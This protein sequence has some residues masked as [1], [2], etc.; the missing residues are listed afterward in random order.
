M[1]SATSRA[2]SSSTSDGYSCTQRQRR[3]R[4]AGYDVIALPDR[5]G[6]QS[7]RCARP[8][9]A[10]ARSPPAKSCGMRRRLLARMHVNGHAVVLEHR[11]ERFGQVAD[12]G[13]WHS[14]DEIQHLAA[15]RGGSGRVQR[16]RAASRKKLRS[17]KRGSL[18]PWA[19]P[20]VFSINQRAR[21][22]RW[23]SWP[24]AAHR[25]QRPTS[26][27]NAR[28]APNRWSIARWRDV[29]PFAFDHQLAEYRCWPDIPG[30]TSDS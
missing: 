27:S 26:R 7:A 9:C 20:S 4:L 17:A 15:A 22:W 13:N 1:L 28:H 23:P 2:S 8:L 30:G 29:G 12:R 10:P 11:D 14:V 18:R 3:R 16:R 21:D 25:C 24:A 5:L 6:Q 19:M